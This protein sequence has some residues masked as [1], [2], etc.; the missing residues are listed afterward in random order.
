MPKR[1]IEIEPRPTYLYVRLAGP[2]E[3][4]A[5]QAD[6]RQF[7]EAGAAHGLSRFLVNGLELTGRPS[8]A[9]RYAYSEYMAKEVSA[10]VAAGRLK[11]PRLAYVLKPPVADNLLFGL[12]VAVNRGIDATVTADLDKALRWLDGPERAR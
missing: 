8:V 4:A 11:R 12:T 1:L 7:L 5:A 9:D 6:G 3:L 10:L 2:F